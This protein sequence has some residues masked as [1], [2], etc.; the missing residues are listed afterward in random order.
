MPINRPPLRLITCA[1]AALAL[2]ATFA[3]CKKSVDETAEPQAVAVQA[4]KAEL[5]DLTEY[6]TGDAILS[7]LAQAAIVPKISA[8]IKRFYVQRGARVRQGQLLATLENADL[9]AAVADNGGSLK[10]AQAAFE[11]ATRAQIPEDQQKAQFDVAQNKANLDVAKSILDARKRLLDQGGI[12]R[13]DYDST[14]R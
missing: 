14:L 7:P 4:E 6:A 1:L 11:T 13:R 8:P 2:S 10:Q 12:P 3:G 5:K 9:A